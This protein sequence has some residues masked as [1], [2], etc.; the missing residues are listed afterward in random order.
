MH[1]NVFTFIDEYFHIGG[2][3]NNG[4]QWNL[5]DSIQQFKKEKGI[6]DNHDLQAYF[7]NRVLKILTQNNKK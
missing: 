2:D 3:E 1:R 4:K 6:K 7:N 5:N